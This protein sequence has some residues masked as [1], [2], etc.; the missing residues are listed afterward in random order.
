MLV[1]GDL[2]CPPD[3]LFDQQYRLAGHREFFDQGIGLRGDPRLDTR[4]GFVD[5]D[6]AGIGHQAARPLE[7]PLLAAAEGA[8]GLPSIYPADGNALVRPLHAVLDATTV[9]TS[10][11]RST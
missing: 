1:V 11:T 9:E 3:V 2:L 8:G 5:E 4:R 6:E 7:L 10:R